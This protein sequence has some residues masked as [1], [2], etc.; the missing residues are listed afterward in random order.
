VG[1]PHADFSWKER[2]PVNLNPPLPPASGGSLCV[3]DENGGIVLPPALSNLTNLQ[4]IF[5]GYG[6]STPPEWLWDMRNLRALSICNDRIETVPAEIGRLKNLRKLCIYGENISALPD[7]IGLLPLTVLDLQCPRLTT[8]PASFSGLKKMGTLSVT[9]CNFSVVPGFI[10]G[11]TELEAL[12][13]YMYNT[14]QGPVTKLTKIPENIGNLKKL[15]VLDLESTCIAELPESL[16]ECPLEYLNLSGDLKK[17]PENF[18]KLTALK[19]LDLSAYE[20]QRLPQSFGSLSSLEKFTFRG[21][22]LKELPES[23]GNLSSLKDLTIMTG[24]DILLPESFGRLSALEEFYI[25]AE[26]MKALPESIGKCGTLKIFMLESDAFSELPPS[27]IKLVNLEEFHADT[28]AL[29]KLPAGFGNLGALK[30]LEIFS[31]ALTVFPKSMGKLRNLKSLYLDAHN[32]VNLP[33]SFREL[34]Y[35]KQ[36]HIVTGGRER[37]I[38]YPSPVKRSGTAAIDFDDLKYMSWRY[39]RKIL[40]ACSLKELEDLLHRAPHH[41]R[42]GETGKDIVRDILL[43]R[44]ILLNRKFKWIPENIRRIATVSGK[45]LAAWEAGF[46]KAKSVIDVLYEKEPDKEAFWDNYDVE[47]TLEPEI[48]IKNPESSEFEYPDNTVYPV[49]IDYLDSNNAL[50]IGIKYNPATKDESGFREDLHI[51]RK[52][53]WNIEGFGD[54]DLA[55]QYICY[56]IHILYSHHE[57]ANEDILRINSIDSQVSITRLSKGGIF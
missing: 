56:A 21:G 1:S 31:G 11:W 12:I 28:F 53:S 38:A 10:C 32:V 54:I 4:N 51:S 52:L 24:A 40:G 16:C 49:L 22:S 5:L 34:S 33:E 6:V 26:K 20:L 30:S 3:E 35:V 18:G 36:K 19:K 45:F 14:F 47:L 42:A 27:F 57:W 43:R 48:L 23:A 7:E 50:N 13:V 9:S 46:A 37:K 8:L 55:D 44:K 17:L 25:D 41:F 29:K 15:R 39:R 2:S